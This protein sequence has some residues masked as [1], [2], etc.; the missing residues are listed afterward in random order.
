LVSRSDYQKQ[1]AQA[2]EELGFR[3]VRFHG[4]FVDDMSVVLPAPDGM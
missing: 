4:L 1:L 2:R 3:Q